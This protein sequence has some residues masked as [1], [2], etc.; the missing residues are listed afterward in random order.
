VQIVITLFRL[1]GSQEHRSF[2]L[3]A[4]FMHT[5]HAGREYI[6]F[7]VRLDDLVF[8][9]EQEILSMPQGRE[10][11]LVEVLM[12]GCIRVGLQVDSYLS[13]ISES[14]WSTMDMSRCESPSVPYRWAC[15][16]GLRSRV[17]H[18][19]PPGVYRGANQ[20]IDPGNKRQNLASLMMEAASCSAGLQNAQ[21][22]YRSRLPADSSGTC[23]CRLPA[24]TF[25]D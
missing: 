17:A 2:F 16:P 11:G 12:P 14:G 9:A 15:S 23:A 13:A 21:G 10:R 6:L 19:L 7:Q 4:S 25:A 3:E 1:S 5:G 8:C 24:R 20:H 22:L 18:T